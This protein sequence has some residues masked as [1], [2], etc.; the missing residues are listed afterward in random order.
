MGGEGRVLGC[1]ARGKACFEAIRA[2]HQ[3]VSAI[4]S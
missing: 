2:V 3:I 1:R 4:L